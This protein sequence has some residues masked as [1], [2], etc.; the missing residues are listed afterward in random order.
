MNFGDRTYP[1][2]V[3]DLLTVLTGGTVSESHAIGSQLP[4]IISLD[5]RPVRR[6][7]HLQGRV[8]A[9]EKQIDYRF[10]ERDFELVGSDANPNQFVAIRFRP[11]GNKP[12]LNSVLTVNYYPERL[13]P[14]PLTDVNIGSVARTLIETVSRELAT[15]YQQLQIVYE[16]AFVET[17]KGDSLDKVAALVDTLRLLEGHPVG[18]VRFSRR[19]GS[20]GSVFIPVS[21]AVSDGEG[22]RY[23]TSTEATLLPNQ[24][25]VEVWVHGQSRTGK[26]VEAGKLTVLERAISGIDRVTNDEATYRAT[27]AETDDQFRN[28]ARRAIHATGK[29]TLDAL[30]YGLEGL[31]FVSAVTLSEYPDPSVPLPGMLRVDIAL[32]EDNE[33]NRRIAD[34]RVEELRPAGIYVERHWAGKVTLAFKVDLLLAGSSLPTSAVEDIKSGITERLSNFARHLGPGETLRTS[35]LIALA[36]E[37]DRIVEAKIAATADGAPI[38]GD[39]YILPTGKAAALDSTAPVTFGGIAFEQSAGTQTV[40]V[41]LDAEIEA[42]SLSLDRS[43]LETQLKAALDTFAGGL[44]PG[45][46]VTFDNLAGAVRDDAK[47]AMV[48][49]RTVFAFDEEGGGFTELRDNDPAYSAPLNST[50]QVRAL[51][52]TET[53]S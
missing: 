5:Q 27:E 22:N 16:S 33:L 37:D 31:T 15:Q 38:S 7:S 20:P 41:H 29:G 8:M 40:V 18:K 17:A 36:L 21:T 9:G 42:T 12:A 6:V 39:S 46:P 2:I 52:I 34:S 10:T 32:S 48:R 49:S 25:T 47:Y 4:D 51:R 13:R 1:D 43:A 50:V 24:A 26:P 45:A 28:R 30:R 35:R 11:R 3:R 23:L 14:T 19:S 53:A 44:Q